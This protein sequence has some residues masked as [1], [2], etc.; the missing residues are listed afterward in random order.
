NTVLWCEK[1]DE[2]YTRRFAQ[3]VDRLAPFAI[4]TGV[5]GHESEPQALELFEMIAFEHVNAG[6]HSRRAARAL[7][8]KSKLLHAR[9]HFVVIL[10]RLR[11]R[12]L[13]RRRISDR[14]RDNRR[15]AP[16]Q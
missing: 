15:D 2:F 10:R 8:A 1:R 9:D 13:D 11:T 7:T 4:A 6:Q 3:H 16:A 5:I 12:A 14:S